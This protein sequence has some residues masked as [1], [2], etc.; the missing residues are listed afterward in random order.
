MNE[1]Q[2]TGRLYTI[3]EAA[4]EV[5]VSTSTLKQWE[6]RTRFP[7]GEFPTGSEYILS[8]IYSDFVLSRSAGYDCD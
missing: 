3:G 6:L 2:T 4:N 7:R 8:T 5:E 1:Q